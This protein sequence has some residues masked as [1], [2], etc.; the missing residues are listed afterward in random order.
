MV[1][2]LDK[3]ENIK[4]SMEVP[5]SMESLGKHPYASPTRDAF[6]ALCLAI[7]LSIW[8]LSHRV[9]EDIIE[10]CKSA[11]A[12]TPTISSYMAEVSATKCICKNVETQKEQE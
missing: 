11:C 3:E 10:E 2:G 9:S 7:A 12:S 4:V 8:A 1:I 6:I 5:C